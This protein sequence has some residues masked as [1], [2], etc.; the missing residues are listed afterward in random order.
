MKKRIVWWLVFLGA[1]SPSLALFGIYLFNPRLLGV[2]PIEVLLQENGEFA[3]RFLVASLACSPIKRLGWKGIVRYRRMFGL[4]AFYYATLH[5]LTYLI[6]WIEF[7]WIVFGEDIVERPFIYLGLI[8]WLILLA[9]A[10]TSPKRMVKLLKK[11]WTRIHKAVYLSASL[12]CVHLWMQSRAS[13]GEAVF[14]AALVFVLLFERAFQ[15]YRKKGLVKA[16]S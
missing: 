1:I 5:L 16:L 10:L 4:F 8:S 9:L 6:G 13:V 2:D 7:D 14:Y 12:V 15:K 11:N 3:L